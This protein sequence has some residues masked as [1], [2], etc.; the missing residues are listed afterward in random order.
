MTAPRDGLQEHRQAVWG[1]AYR[2]L[3]VPADADDVVQD[4]FVKA[5]EHPPATDRPIR[6]WLVR[7]ATNLSLDR[8]RARRR[9][10]YVG[11]WLPG[12]ADVSALPDPAPGAEARYGALESSSFAFLLALEALTPNQRAVL[13]LRDVL[14]WSGRETAQALGLSET[15]AKVTLHRARRALAAYDRQPCR[16][17]PALVERTTQA[18]G[19]FLGALA[20]GDPSAFQDALTAEARLLSDGGGEFFAAKKPVVGAAKIG[21][22]YASL[23]VRRAQHGPGMPQLEVVVL[24]GLPAL[25]CADLDAPPGD[26]RRWVMRCEVDADGRVR[27][28]HSILATRKL[29]GLG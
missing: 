10:G 1:V 20:S 6:P 4:T 16:P 18:L 17:D 27:E 13:L 22:L 14:D 23:L 19:R 28:L 7:V 26:A 25:L 8:L 12:P 21:G 29:A 2:M 15:N 24:N 3:G 9:R 5:L 11:P